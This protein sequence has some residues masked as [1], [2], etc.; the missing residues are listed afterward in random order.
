MLR[1]AHAIARVRRAVPLAATTL[2]AALTA[3][4]PGLA[5]AQDG[6]GDGFSGSFLIG[7]RSVDVNGAERKFREDLD[8]DDGPRLFE[9]RLDLA[10]EGGLGGV[11]DRVYFD[12]DQYTW[13][14]VFYPGGEMRVAMLTPS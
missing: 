14:V 8:L 7:L 2:A 11:A 5:R 3:V 12:A 1:Q 6:A 10:P 9:F 4:A 13:F